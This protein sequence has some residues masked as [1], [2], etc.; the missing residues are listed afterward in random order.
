MSSRVCR[1][2]KRAKSTVG[3][4][5]MSGTLVPPVEVTASML[6]ELHGEG[7]DGGQWG[8]GAY[9][10][11]GAGD[12]AGG[13]AID[14]AAAAGGE[15]SCGGQGDE[16]EEEFVEGF[17][18]GLGGRRGEGM[19]RRHRTLRFL[20]AAH[21]FRTRAELASCH[22]PQ[23]VDWCGR[24]WGALVCGVIAGVTFYWGG[25]ESKF[26]LLSDTSQPRRH[27][28]GCLVVKL[29]EKNFGG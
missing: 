7:G 10:E 26:E 4:P 14:R 20:R 27:R 25:L 22:S 11:C 18:C 9:D 13:A 23:N 8:V 21:L 12:A 28:A 16:G 6:I 3:D 15:Q 17:G 19:Q 1:P 24:V 5:L 29:D 2:L